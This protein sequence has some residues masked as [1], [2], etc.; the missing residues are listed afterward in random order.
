ML[1]ME[2]VELKRGRPT[3]FG[4]WAG[5]LSVSEESVVTQR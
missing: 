4:S 5:S 1:T 3:V 2:L